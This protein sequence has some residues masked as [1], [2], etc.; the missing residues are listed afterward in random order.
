MALV[1]RLPLCTR[2]SCGSRTLGELERLVLRAGRFS[3]EVREPAEWGVAGIAVEC[4]SIASLLPS[5]RRGTAGW[6]WNPT[7]VQEKEIDRDGGDNA[8]IRLL[9]R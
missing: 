4:V 8:G 2:A 9:R 6:T 7:D 5:S 1:E 3:S